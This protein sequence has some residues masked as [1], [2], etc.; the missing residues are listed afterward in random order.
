MRKLL[1]VL[2]GER[3]T[4]TFHLGDNEIVLQTLTASEKSELARLV[5]GLDFLAQ[6]ENQKVP[7]IARSLVSINKIP[8]DNYDE[9]IQNIRKYEDDNVSILKCIELT[10]GSMDSE[11]V[12]LLYNYYL[13]LEQEKAK[14]REALKNS[15][16]ALT[17]MQ[18]NPDQSGKSVDTSK[19][20]QKN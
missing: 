3:L 18:E 12:N 20:P 14:E 13:E 11:A 9:V 10:L 16:R 1:Q 4:K 17:A 5:S 15:S 6:L 19:E 8:I 7:T 2:S